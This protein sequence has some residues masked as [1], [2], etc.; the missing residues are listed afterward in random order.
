MTLPEI[1]RAIEGLSE[2]EQ[3]SLATWV[4]ERDFALWDAEIARDFSTGGAGSALLEDVRRQVRQGRSK[5]LADGP[6]RALPS[7]HSPSQ[8]SG[9]VMRNCRLTF[10]S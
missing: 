1:Q 6:H 3:A 9:S 8:N 7:V 10:E 2:E 5:P 4:A